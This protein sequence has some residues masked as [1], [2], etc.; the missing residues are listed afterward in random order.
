MTEAQASYTTDIVYPSAFGAFQS[1]VHLIQAAWLGGRTGPDLSAPFAYADLGCGAGM[2]LC[3][4]AACYPQARFH[5]VDINPE[6]IRLAR[7]LATRAELSNVAFHHRSFAELDTLDL[8]P[9]DFVGLSGVYSWLTPDLRQACLGF[10]ARRLTPAGLVFL[11]YGALPGNAQ[12]DALYALIREAARTS[13]GDS[14]DQFRFGCAAADRM[15]QAGARFFRLNPQ[16]SAW[17]DQLSRQDPRAMAHEVLNAQRASLSARDAAEEAAAQGLTF[18]ANAQLELNDLGL[19]APDALR[20]ELAGYPPVA[21]EMLMDAMRDTH[22]RMDVLGLSDAPAGAADPPLWVDRLSRGP[23]TEERRTFGQRTGLDLMTPAYDEVLRRVDGQAVELG[24]L[25]AETGARQEIQR[26][27]ALKLAHL[28]RQ[29][30]VP[31]AATEAPRM[32]SRLNTLVLEERIDAAG[33]IPFA[34]PVAGTQVLLPP[35]DRLALLALLDGDFEAA[36][37]RVKAAGQVIKDAG[38]PVEDARG[39]RRAA[40]RRA[41]AIGARILD[42]LCRLGVVERGGA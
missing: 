28:L 35:Q 9:L 18:V 4:L 33:V 1:P 15:R 7:D 29:P 5:G 26:L 37:V 27:A 16:A 6:H 12:I 10:A 39:L 11:H 40:D 19:T 22:S 38:V 32:A 25:I 34:S 41:A 31:T 23:L 3:V 13:P 36:W 17:L 30:Y 8:P 20:D 21:R 14:L 2:T 42:D 24:R